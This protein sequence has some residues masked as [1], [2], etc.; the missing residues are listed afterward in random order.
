MGQQREDEPSAEEK[1][2]TLTPDE[3]GRLSMSEYREWRAAVS[4]PVPPSMPL[5]E[6]MTPEIV[7]TTTME[8]YRLWRSEQKR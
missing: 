6:Q 3:V 5:L 8:Q 1:L 4:V 2:R 7:G